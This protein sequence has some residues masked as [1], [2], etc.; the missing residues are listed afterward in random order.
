MWVIVN[1]PMSFMEVALSGR[2]HA[3]S[4]TL[5]PT[6]G[7]TLEG[8]YCMLQWGVSPLSC[9]FATIDKSLA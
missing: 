2:S 8:A 7:L 6:V 1:G 3:D 9:P 4:M 5:W